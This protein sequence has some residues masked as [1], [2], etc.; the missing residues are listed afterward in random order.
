MDIVVCIKWT[1]DTSE[2]ELAIDK[3]GKDVGKGELDFDINDWDRFA[4]EE[5]VQIKERAGGKVTVVTVAPEDAEEILRESLAR[6]ADEAFHLW[7]ESFEGSDGYATAKILAK[8]IKGRAFD[9]ILT[10]TLADD[11][12]AG[13]VGGMLAA[14]LDVPGASLVHKIEPL[15]GKVKLVRELE[16]GLSEALEMDLPAVISVATGLNEPRFVSIRAVR[17]VAN[18]EIPVVSLDEVGLDQ[19]EVGADGA[20]IVVEEMMLPPE[21]EGAEIIKGSAEEA[22]AR[23][24]EILREKG[25]VV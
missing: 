14:M 23:L 22:A 12:C 25:G 11:D 8:F 21:G 16:G 7:D 9:L 5:A 15:D 24:A 17:K 1:P 6:G 19:A 18:I 4:V 13:Q 2:A 10:G 20:R 3:G